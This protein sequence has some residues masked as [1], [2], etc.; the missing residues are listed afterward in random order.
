MLGARVAEF[1]GMRVRL[2]RFGLRSGSGVVTQYPPFAQQGLPTSV[3]LTAIR[4]VTDIFP[5]QTVE[6][7]CHTYERL[8][9]PEC[10]KLAA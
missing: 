2:N 8:F 5:P 10:R 7:L 6:V 3:P 4:I 1:V 9:F